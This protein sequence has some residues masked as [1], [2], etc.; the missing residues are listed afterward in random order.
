MKKAVLAAFRR[1]EPID[2]VTLLEFTSDVE[3]GSTA[4]EGVQSSAAGHAVKW[5]ELPSEPLPNVFGNGSSRVLRKALRSS[6]RD[7]RFL[8]HERVS[9]DLPI[10]EWAVPLFL[11]ELQAGCIR[12]Y[13][14]VRG[15]ETTTT[16]LLVA[17]GSLQEFA[18]S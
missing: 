13:Q 9:L 8:V 12:R 5:I 16:L 10:R 6:F 3:P 11:C 15:N 17:D 2:T 18:C 4:Q 14:T 1:Q 7:R